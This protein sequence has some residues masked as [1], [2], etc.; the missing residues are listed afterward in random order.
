MS[1][2]GINPPGGPTNSSFAANYQNPIEKRWQEIMFTDPSYQN[3]LQ[4]ARN[5]W[6]SDTFAWMVQNGIDPTGTSR[7]FANVQQVKALQQ[8]D[9]QRQHFEDTI[10]RYFPDYWSVN[11]QAA[12]TPQPNPLDALQA[13]LR[14][15][16]ANGNQPQALAL[17]QQIEQA[18]VAAV[19]QAPAQSSPYATQQDQALAQRF[20][21]ILSR[22]PPQMAM[23]V[24][25]NYG[26]GLS[27]GNDG[28]ISPD[29]ISAWVNQHPEAVSHF[30]ASIGLPS[31]T[32]G[33][34]APM[35]AYAAP[36]GAYGVPPSAP[37]APD[38]TSLIK[39]AAP[40]LFPT[41]DTPPA[42]QAPDPFQAALDPLTSYI[43][44]LRL[45]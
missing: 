27:V 40:T 37:P 7:T 31:T 45:Y 23:A 28:S 9:Q 6:G 14:D 22:M 38:I 43:N 26:S 16:I 25:G 36:S 8:K 35:G 24:T 18:K 5:F 33:S 4:D 15:A 30:S 20:G 32:L 39:Q 3:T 1:V 17:Q 19:H 42:P 21:D 2:P 12:A 11:Q 13:Q 34:A 44:K 29:A 10:Q 41:Q